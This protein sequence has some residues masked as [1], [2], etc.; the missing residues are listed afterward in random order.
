MNDEQILPH[1]RLKLALDNP[2]WQ[3]CYAEGYEMA[4]A[5]VPE[6]ENPYEADSSEHEFWQDGWWDGF[7]G[8]APKFEI[9]ANQLPGSAQHTQSTSVMREQAAN[10]GSWTAVIHHH[11]AIRAAQF[12]GAIAASAAV[13]YQL[14]D[15]AA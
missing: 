4:R 10:E 2:D 14:L 1:I 3:E 11:W 7:Y 6:S 13:A 8:E 15:I 12:A 5:E 9:T